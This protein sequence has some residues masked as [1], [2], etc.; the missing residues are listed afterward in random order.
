MEDT[1]TEEQPVQLDFANP[2]TAYCYDPDTG[3]YTG[4]DECAPDPLESEQAGAP[5]WL[6]PANATLTAPALTPQD[7]QALCWSGEA[8]ELKED[9]RQKR[10]TGGIPIEGTGTAYWL[11]DDTYGMAPR[12]MDTLG[13]L[14]DGAVLTAPA[15]STVQLWEDLRLE[16]DNRLAQCDYLIMPDY[17]LSEEK[18]EQV[19]SYR[20]ALRDLPAQEGAPWD[21][22]GALTPWPSFAGE[23]S[24]TL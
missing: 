10:D 11:P 7:K 2:P 13:P 18:R 17:P 19:E 20:Q 15:K 8:W 12:Y 5:V 21:G 16:R 9:H 22:G 6:L 1:Y 4:T 14:P 23:T 24:Q 3:E